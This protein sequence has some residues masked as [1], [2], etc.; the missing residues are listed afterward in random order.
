MSRR[1]KGVASNYR[2]VKTQ[3]RAPGLISGLSP[4]KRERGSI[5]PINVRRDDETCTQ[6]RG[7]RRRRWRSASSPRTATTTAATAAATFLQRERAFGVF[8]R[9]GLLVLLFFG[10]RNYLSVLCVVVGACRH[11][12]QQQSDYCFS[13]GISYWTE[14]AAMVL[15]SCCRHCRSSSA[16]YLLTGQTGAFCKIG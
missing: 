3:T 8:L 15:Y 9:P 12:E 6:P 14:N 13:A 16:D 10:G 1:A 11:I 4:R 7:R 2:A 5:Q